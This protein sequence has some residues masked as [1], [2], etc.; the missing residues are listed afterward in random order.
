LPPTELLRT[1]FIPWLDEIN[2]LIGREARID[3]GR[4]YSFLTAWRE[5]MSP[6]MAVR[7]AIEWLA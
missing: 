6:S 3:L 2:A 4:S 7:E 5:G 1:S